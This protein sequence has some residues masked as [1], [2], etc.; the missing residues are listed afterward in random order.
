MMA[1]N[2]SGTPPQDFD[3]YH[4]WL[5]IP[6]S[7]QPPNHYRLLGAPLFETEPEVIDNA[8]GSRLTTLR[9]Y[10]SGQHSAQCT[11][12]LNEV[13]KARLCLLRED[14]KAAY[15]A[16][17]QE[18]L[19]AE[20]NADA[21]PTQENAEIGLS[22]RGSGASERASSRRSSGLV[23]PLLGAGLGGVTV[24]VILW[25]L[26]ILPNMFGP[27]PQAKPKIVAEEPREKKPQ[28]TRASET[29][30]PQEERNGNGLLVNQESKVEGTSN[31]DRSFNIEGRLVDPNEKSST[32]SKTTD[33]KKNQDG[34]PGSP[35]AAGSNVV[36]KTERMPSEELANTESP[37]ELASATPSDSSL[38]TSVPAGPKDGTG[39][40]P[41]AES[42]AN[43]KLTE[44]VLA[45]LETAKKAFTD[46]QEKTK[47]QL[48]DQ[49]DKQAEILRKGQAIAIKKIPAEIRLQLTTVVKNERE[50]FV[51]FERPPLSLPMRLHF[52]NYVQSVQNNQVKLNASFQKA[53][54]F[55]TK[56]GK[57]AKAKELV[58]EK[59]RLLQPKLI[60][61][62]DY[63]WKPNATNRDS[64]YSNGTIG[65]SSTSTWR[66]D[67]VNNR[68]IRRDGM[69]TDTLDLSVDGRTMKGSNQFGHAKSATIVDP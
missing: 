66:L 55:Y 52:F 16:Q 69:W 5:G 24:W 62:W 13:S 32:A 39:S 45:K 26:N 19:E 37:T 48:L 51:K 22:I 6:K 65:D 46:A 28:K 59:N 3:G 1:R 67:A 43:V 61:V 44:Q 47:N 68:I 33:A 60:C 34:S 21:T 41:E 31:E 11:R 38:K 50:N 49:F 14:S 18:E 20:S 29:T 7:E 9:Q 36:A 57:D 56:V 42:E 8:A 2:D 30:D 15:D 35:S 54:D 53:V 58:E 25:Q 27:N 12:I 17:L 40:R 63:T 23:G 10:Q 64:F 4:R